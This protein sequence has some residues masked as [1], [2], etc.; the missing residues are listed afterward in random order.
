MP[1][2]ERRTKMSEF[3][4]KLSEIDK[5]ENDNEFMVVEH[6]C[7]RNY[8]FNRLNDQYRKYNNLD[9]KIPEEDMKQI[10]ERDH[11]EWLEVWKAEVEEGLSQQPNTKEENEYMFTG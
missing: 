9:V 10:K 1:G 3:T 11:E 8:Y 7:I 4:K 6:D 2:K 5:I